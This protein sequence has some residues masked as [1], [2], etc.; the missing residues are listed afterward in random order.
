MKNFHEKYLPWRMAAIS[1][2]KKLVLTF[3]AK[4]DQPRESHLWMA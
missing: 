1:P 2:Q 4:E 3:N